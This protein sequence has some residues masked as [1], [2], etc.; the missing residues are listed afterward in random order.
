[1]P[2]SYVMCL[3]CVWQWLISLYDCCYGLAQNN[4]EFIY[5]LLDEMWNVWSYRCQTHH[6]INTLGWNLLFS[7]FKL[8][9]LTFC[10]LTSTNKHLHHMTRWYTWCVPSISGPLYLGLLGYFVIL[11]LSPF[12]GAS[13]NFHHNTTV[14]C[15]DYWIYFSLGWAEKKR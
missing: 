10:L 1:M 15:I 9:Q 3:D 2:F 6:N 7:G 13:H 5:I 11:L 14:L 12:K 4:D 8:W